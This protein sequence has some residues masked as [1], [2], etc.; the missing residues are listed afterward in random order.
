MSNSVP[1][2]VFKK[3][4]PNLDFSS[5][6]NAILNLGEA[7]EVLSN[8]RDGVVTRCISSLFCWWMSW[9]FFFGGTNIVIRLMKGDDGGECS[10]GDPLVLRALNDRLAFAERG[11]LF[12]QGS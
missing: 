10:V 12:Y 4:A 6:N 3:E 1:Q 5:L 2:E 9:F 7:A 11:F 8:T